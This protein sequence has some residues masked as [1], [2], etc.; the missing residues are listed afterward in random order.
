MMTAN[1]VQV[2]SASIDSLN[3]DTLGI[4]SEILKEHSTYRYLDVD[5]EELEILELYPNPNSDRLYVSCSDETIKEA[6]IIIHDVHGVLI[7]EGNIH[8]SRGLDLRNL[9]LNSGVY[10]VELRFELNYSLMSEY[11]KLV[12][13]K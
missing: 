6:A 12:F 3:A 4:P 5:E 11:K 9:S 7:F 10:T 2:L 8:F 1:Q 13:L